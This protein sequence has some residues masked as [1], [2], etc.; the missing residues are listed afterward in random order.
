MTDTVDHKR[1][2][3]AFAHVAG[4]PAG[5]QQ[6][7]RSIALKLPALIQREG[8]AVALHV[9]AARGDGGQR[10]ILDHLALQLGQPDARGLLAHVRGLDAAGT[11]RMTAEVQRCLA[12]YKRFVQIAATS[13][14]DAGAP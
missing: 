5:D 1:A 7:Y 13:A 3:L 14:P 9:V 10:Q 4:V 8:V 6:K 2:R 11:R 12:W